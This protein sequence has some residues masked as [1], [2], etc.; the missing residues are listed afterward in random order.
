MK[1][2]GRRS[3]ADEEARRQAKEWS[4]AA[5][6]WRMKESGGRSLVD[7]G[8][9]SRTTGTVQWDCEARLWILCASLTMCG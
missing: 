9:Q 7:E 2:G 3:R 6:A 4:E 1:P 8:V 5:T